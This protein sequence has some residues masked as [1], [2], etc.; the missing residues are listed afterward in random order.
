MGERTP[1]D[2]FERL[3]PRAKL[4]ALALVT[5]AASFE[6]E[7]LIGLYLIV[8]VLAI[9]S[10]L[11]KTLVLTTLGGVIIWL[12]FTNLLMPLAD[13]VAQ[14]PFIL[15]AGLV[16]RLS[17]YSVIGIWFA[18]KTNLYDF[19][20]SLE[21]WR[22]PSYVV[23]PF[24][25]AIRFVPTLLAEFAA[26]RDA[27]RQRRLYMGPISVIRNPALS[28]RYFITPMLIRSLRMADELTVAAETRGISRLCA[29]SYYRDLTFTP[30]EYAFVSSVVLVLAANDLVFR[31]CI[32][33]WF[34]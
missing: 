33:G 5:L 4:I 1:G 18:V 27:M 3:D 9:A 31:L 15:F 32:T 12:G 11:W 23:L 19:G 20:C 8:S 2:F 29:R 13:D 25:I 7:A 14:D 34:R 28:L 22:V 16:L 17:I 30:R 24:I 10:G 21:K 6:R 26:I